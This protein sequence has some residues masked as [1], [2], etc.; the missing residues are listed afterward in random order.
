MTT[1]PNSGSPK[2]NICV[3]NANTNVWWQCVHRDICVDKHTTHVVGISNVAYIEV[4][5]R[6]LPLI[7]II[8][9]L[10]L[11]P[12]CCHGE[13]NIFCLF[14]LNFFHV[15]CR[16]R[17]SSLIKQTPRMDSAFWL[18]SYG[19]CIRA[20]HESTFSNWIRRLLKNPD[21]IETYA[22]MEYAKNIPDA[23][24]WR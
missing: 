6:N 23:Y 15:C 12:Q 8:Y 20:W 19:V 2:P 10:S 13:F 9:S 22:K 3:P 4:A 21:R 1:S 7:I 18:L 5:T 16:R 14:N 11:Q 24:G 17:L